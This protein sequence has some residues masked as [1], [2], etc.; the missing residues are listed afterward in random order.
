MEPSRTSVTAAYL[1]ISS[2]GVAVDHGGEVE[3]S[4]HPSFAGWVTC[5]K[6]TRGLRSEAAQFYCFPDA[7]MIDRM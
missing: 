2:R 7:G 4:K 3:L 5:Q 6:E 1:C